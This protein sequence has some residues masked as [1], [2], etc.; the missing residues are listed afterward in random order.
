[1]CHEGLVSHC[2]INNFLFTYLS[3][4]SS[5]SSWLLLSKLI[6]HFYLLNL[7][8]TSWLKYFPGPFFP[9]WATPRLVGPIRENLLTRTSPLT[10]P[11][12]VFFFPSPSDLCCMLVKHV[13]LWRVWFDERLNKHSPVIFL[14]ANS[15]V[16]C[17]FQEGSNCHGRKYIVLV[18]IIQLLLAYWY[19]SYFCNYN[20]HIDKEVKPVPRVMFKKMSEKYTNTPIKVFST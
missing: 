5:H 16:L 19:E 4:L 9:I 10:S 13:D 7:Y 20:S 8:F 17:Q 1:M 6:L 15:S 2:R 11:H 3:L 18:L 14:I 12:P